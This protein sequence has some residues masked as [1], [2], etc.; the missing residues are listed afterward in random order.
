MES[1]TEISKSQPHAAHVAF[2]KGFKSKFTYYLRTI[3]SFEEYVDP[4]EEVIHTSFLLSLFGQVEPLPEE[5]K[6]LVILSTA[7]GGIGIPDLKRESSEQFNASLDI[8]ASHVN[9]IVTQRSTIPGRELMEEWKREINAQSSAATKSR[10]DRIDELL[11]P[12]LLQVVQQT[13]DKGASSWLN[14]IPIKEHGLPLN[15]QEFRD[16]LCLCYNLPLSN[17]PSYCACGEMFNFNHTLSC[18][19]GCFFSSET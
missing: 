2:T 8:T 4:I 7:Q 15:K 6:G 17:L 5:L 3:E 14:A 11:S 16:S 1:L 12:D 19:K 13:G 10:I 9:S 18:K